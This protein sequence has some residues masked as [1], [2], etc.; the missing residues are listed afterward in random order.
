[1]KA[2]AEMIFE[3]ESIVSAIS[4][5]ISNPELNH[6]LLRVGGELNYWHKRCLFMEAI[7][8]RNGN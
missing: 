4:K 6:I 5:H 3:T 1:M 7:N 2:D 8:E